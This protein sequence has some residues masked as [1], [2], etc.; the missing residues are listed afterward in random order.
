MKVVK[1]KI[2]ILNS[3]LHTDTGSVGDMVIGRFPKLVVSVRLA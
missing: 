3:F 1:Q 2:V